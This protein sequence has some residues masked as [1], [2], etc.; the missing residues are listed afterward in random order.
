MPKP[1]AA[2]TDLPELPKAE[3]D[4]PT[5]PAPPIPLVP[6]PKDELEAE[7]DKSQYETDT[8]SDVETEDEPESKDEPE[9]KTDSSEEGEKE[10][11]PDEPEPPKDV[12]GGIVL[13]GALHRGEDANFR[14]CLALVLTP[15]NERH[16]PTFPYWSAAA[17]HHGTEL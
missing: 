9:A 7:P 11:K 17:R 6:G 16:V 3:E 12:G 1:G 15:R 10:E 8:E 4:A 14:A 5:P 2:K 13:D